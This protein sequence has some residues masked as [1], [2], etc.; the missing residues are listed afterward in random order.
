MIALAGGE[1]KSGH[2]DRVQ[3][4]ARWRGCLRI[5]QLRMDERREVSGF[6]AEYP[7]ARLVRGKITKTAKTG[8]D[9]AAHLEQARTLALVGGIEFERRAIRQSLR[10]HHGYRREAVCER[11][12]VERVELVARCRAID[13]GD[14]EHLALG[15]IDHRRARDA[16][17]R[18]VIPAAERR[19]HGCT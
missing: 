13:I 11:D 18:S 17:V 4:K 5:V 3:E 10:G 7:A 12:Q 8:V 6:P 15:K 9:V 14:Q 19:R 1:A 16:N 2:P